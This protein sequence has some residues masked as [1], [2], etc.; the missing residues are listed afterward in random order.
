MY[1]VVT[2]VFGGSRMQVQLEN[3]TLVNC[4]I[5]GALRRKSVSFI[6]IGTYVIVEDTMITD[7]APYGFVFQKK[8]EEFLF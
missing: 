2:K 7:L 4:S 5:R 6:G 1:G 8:E 3:G